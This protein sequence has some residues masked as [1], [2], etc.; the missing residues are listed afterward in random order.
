MKFY[1]IEVITKKC[2]SDNFNTKNDYRFNKTV[3]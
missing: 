3:Q 1:I 2:L